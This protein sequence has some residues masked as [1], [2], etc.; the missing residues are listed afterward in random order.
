MR[1]EPQRS[2]RVTEPQVAP[3]APHSSESVSGLHTQ[4][5]PEHCCV[6]ALHV[7]GQA[8][9]LPQAFESEP[10]ATP[11]QDSAGQMHCPDA[12]HVRSFVQVP[13]LATVRCT[14]Q[15]C[16]MVSPSQTRLFAMQSW[17]LL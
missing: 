13:Q 12:S 8:T 14:P 4:L 6:V 10:H 11:E 2:V 17:V 9:E 16:V 7:F 1:A 3:A 15:L 5:F